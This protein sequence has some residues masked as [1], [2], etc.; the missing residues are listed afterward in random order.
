MFVFVWLISSKVIY[1][2]KKNNGGLK[3][4]KFGLIYVLYL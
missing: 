1:Y 4:I 3:M 2:L